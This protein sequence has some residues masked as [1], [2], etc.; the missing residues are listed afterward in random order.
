MAFTTFIAWSSG[1][2]LNEPR[3]TPEQHRQAN[4]QHNISLAIVEHQGI[5]T[6]QNQH[7]PGHRVFEYIPSTQN[8]ARG[9][10]YR[11]QAPGRGVP[12][13]P[14][15][16]DN[17]QAGGRGHGNRGGNQRGNPGGN[18]GGNRG[19]GG[20]NQQG[21]NGFRRGGG[22]GNGAGAGGGIAA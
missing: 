15:G 7:I 1:T 3:L 22:G 2:P 4:Q 9:H 14:N 16:P 17:W 11:P 8:P 20:G 12:R 13:Q 6:D 21:G 10:L 5:H 18:R 19:G